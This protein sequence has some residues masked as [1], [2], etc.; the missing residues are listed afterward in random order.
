MGLVSGTG[1]NP[2][3]TAV[4][5]GESL[6]LSGS[7]AFMV[8]EP[9]GRALRVNVVQQLSVVPDHVILGTERDRLALP[10]P[11]M[12]PRPVRSQPVDF[13]AGWRSPRVS[14]GVITDAV[15]A[16]FTAGELAYA[17]VLQPRSSTAA[18]RWTLP[19]GATQVVL[20]VPDHAILASGAGLRGGDV[21]T[22]RG[23]R[24]VRWSGGPIAPGGTFAIRLEGLPAA[25]SRWPEAVAGFLGIALA[26]GLIAALRR[27]PLAV[28]RGGEAA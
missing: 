8:I 28:Q 18:L 27:R 23:R 15:P 10:L 4:E 9:A 19:Y 22:E 17:V 7:T 11:E 14:N 13:V 1:A 26:C 2:V 21:V 6:P 5:T 12:S 3:P 20:L 24:Y 25:D 16:L